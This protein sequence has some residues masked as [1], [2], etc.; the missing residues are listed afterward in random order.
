MSQRILVHRRPWD[1]GPVCPGLQPRGPDLGRHLGGVQTI[2]CPLAGFNCGA[3]AAGELLLCLVHASDSQVGGHVYGLCLGR[4]SHEE[5]PRS[6]DNEPQ[7]LVPAAESELRSGHSS[8]HC[9]SSAGA[10]ATS[11]VRQPPLAPCTGCL[12]F[13]RSCRRRVGGA[14]HRPRIWVGAQR[15]SRNVARRPGGHWSALCAGLADAK[16]PWLSVESGLSKRPWVVQT[17]CLC[18]VS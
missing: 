18:V 8:Q 4:S 15:S 16:V 2:R 12:L 10:M 3:A 17:L 1:C 9:G 14:G 13:C 5:W 6:S 7:V 11:S